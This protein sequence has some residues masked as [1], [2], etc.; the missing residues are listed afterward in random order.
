MN[1]MVAN[2]TRQENVSNTVDEDGTVRKASLQ[3]FVQIGV[4]IEENIKK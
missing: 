2:R 1:R 3:G 4:A